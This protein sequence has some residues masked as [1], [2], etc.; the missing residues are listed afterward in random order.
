MIY[1][2][3]VFNIY[4]YI[5]FRIFRG[6]CSRASG[7][8]RSYS[9]SRGSKLRSNCPASALS[10]NFRLPCVRPGRSDARRS[11]LG[12][13]GGRSGVVFERPGSIFEVEIAVFSMLLRARVRARRT[14]C[15][16]ASDPIKLMYRAHRSCPASTRGRRK[17][18]RN[19]LCKPFSKPL[20]KGRAKNSL[21]ALS[22]ASWER[23]GASLERPKTSW[24]PPGSV[25]GAS[26]GSPRPLW[27]RSGHVPG[28]PCFAKIAPRAIL[29]DFCSIFARFW[30]LL[31][32]PGTSKERPGSD[33]D[34]FCVCRDRTFM[35]VCFCS[36][37]RLFVRSFARSFVHWRDEA[38]RCDSR[39]TR[40]SAGCCCLL[41]RPLLVR[42][43]ACSLVRIHAVS[44]LRSS[45]QT[46][47]KT[48]RFRVASFV[49]LLELARTTSTI[50]PTTCELTFYSLPQ[51]KG[52]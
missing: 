14:C 49:F 6:W 40:I 16:C 22:E 18:A 38:S 33:F 29:L 30:P 45:D 37:A 24:E 23:P 50:Y 13:F 44:S 10:L 3:I 36:F 2:F 21:R 41:F 11:A 5:S 19:S 34:V 20:R 12:A 32:R 27:E 26:R 35:A 31:D 43:F 42:S 1:L 7:I 9:G 25:Q 39:L 47:N 28:N 46:K 4:I 17:I 48:R 15:D 51:G 8:E 52:T